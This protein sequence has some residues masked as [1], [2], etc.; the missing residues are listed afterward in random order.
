VILWSAKGRSPSQFLVSRFTRLY[1]LYWM[2]IAITVTVLMVCTNRVFQPLQLLANTTMLAGYLGQDYVDGVYWT[3]QVEL[4]FYA[5]IFFLILFRQ[6]SNLEYWLIAWLLLSILDVSPYSISALRMI[7]LGAYAPYFIAGGALFLARTDGV[8]PKRLVMVLIC[9][10]LSIVNS[11]HQADEYLFHGDDGVPA[12]LVGGLYLV[13]TVLALG[14][15]KIKESSVLVML[16]MTTYPFYLLHSE[17]GKAIYAQIGLNRYVAVVIATL[18][19][20][21]L[22][23]LVM[24]VDRPVSAY[25]RTLLLSRL[26]GGAPKRRIESL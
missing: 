10:V 1:P 18:F 4:K 7:T 11:H 5:L 2:C 22:S 26:D 16:S 25:L 19:C 8:T 9:A 20:W 14:L 3:L 21:L 12:I 23:Y 17:I 6:M 24:R 13:T 15:L